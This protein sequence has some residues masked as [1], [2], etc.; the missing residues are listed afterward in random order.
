MK[1]QNLN[2][3]YNIIR[4]L[5]AGG[6]GQTY[7]AEDLQMPSRRRCVIKQLKPIHNSTQIYQLVQE[8]FQREAT[9]LEELGGNNPQI[10]SLYAYFEE[11]GQFYLVQEWI[12]GVTLAYQLQQNGNL[13]ENSVKEILIGILPVLDYVHSKQIVHRDIK[14]ENIILRAVDGKPVLIDFGAVRETMGTLMNSQENSTSSIVIGTPGFMPSEQAAGRPV[15]ASDLYSLGLT[16]IYLLTRKPPQ[17]LETDSHTGEIIWQ[18]HCLNITPTFAAI[19]TKAIQSHP[20]DRYSSANEMLEDLQTGIRSSSPTITSSPPKRKFPQTTTISKPPQPQSSGQT[21]IFLGSL[22]GGILISVSVIVWLVLTRTPQESTAQNVAQ[23]P[24]SPK[25]PNS[26]IGVY[27]ETHQ[28]PKPS[29]TLLGGTQLIPEVSHSLMVKPSPST[30]PLSTP[31]ASPINTNRFK[32]FLVKSLDKP[33]LYLASTTLL[34]SDG[35]RLKADFRVYCPTS[36]IRPTNYVLVNDK[37]TVKK[38]G[39]WWE[40]SFT[41]KYDSEHQLIKE[42]CE[43]K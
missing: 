10:P 15:Y 19:L 4:T 21:G 23:T 42:V 38:Q 27:T 7:L 9:I 2:N 1:P 39:L 14:P 37:G 13:S 17:E 8:R 24:S 30:Q 26:P 3:R 28:V 25:P 41:P 32:K 43:R 29:P 12:D 34:Y 5:G 11:N 6:F 35:D 18:P 36:T 22:I 20:R 40:H 31:T 16:A 33:G